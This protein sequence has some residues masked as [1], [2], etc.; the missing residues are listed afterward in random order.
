MAVMACTAQ[1][2][3]SCYYEWDTC[4]I[5]LDTTSGF[6]AVAD[7][8]KGC[9]LSASRITCII[10]IRDPTI[11]NRWFGK[12]MATFDGKECFLA[13]VPSAACWP[14]LQPRA[15]ADII[16]ARMKQRLRETR[17]DKC[18]GFSSFQ[19]GKTTR[20]GTS[21][22]EIALVAGRSNSETRRGGVQSNLLAGDA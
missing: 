1:D 11:R 21:P 8:R 2:A 19:E 5:R 20:S 13:E 9:G 15:K 10:G 17:A 16:K 14:D 7:R 12:W 3:S 18:C 4:R 22:S 6:G